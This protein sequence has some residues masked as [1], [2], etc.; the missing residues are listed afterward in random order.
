[1]LTL[2]TVKTNLRIDYDEDD[3]YLETLILAS[4]MY[5]DGAIEDRFGIKDDPRYKVLQFMLV[6]NWFENRVPT[7]SA[8]QQEVP[9]TIRG[10]IHQLRGVLEDGTDQDTT[11]G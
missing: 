6:A 8:Y 5:I 4:E 11:V 9:Y 1:M 10:M 3:A 7:T 2:E